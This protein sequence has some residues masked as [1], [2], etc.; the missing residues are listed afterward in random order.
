MHTSP[1]NLGRSEVAAVIPRQDDSEGHACAV[2][3]WPSER[4][5]RGFFLSESERSL[6]AC[7]CLVSD[8]LEQLVVPGDVLVVQG[9]TA[10]GQVGVANGPLGQ[11]LLVAATPKSIWQHSTEAHKFR[12]AW[13]PGDVPELWKVRT[14]SVR[15]QRDLCIAE[16]LLYVETGTGRFKIAGEITEDLAI[17]VFDTEAVEIWQSP[18]ELRQ[19]LRGDLVNDV[20]EDMT[21]ESKKSV[22]STTSRQPHEH[23]NS[24]LSCA[25]WNCLDVGG[26]TGIVEVRLCLHICSDRLLAEIP[27]QTCLRREELRPRRATE[28][29][30]GAGVS[31]DASSS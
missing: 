20:L 15:R 19:G 30:G 28:E 8:S 14:L 27:V 23:Q 25:S 31:M 6:T 26:C 2:P 10:V 12:N 9:H 18:T 13:P 3:L 22:Q 24:A 1:F 21:M 11:L 17:V 29:G 7:L 5:G 16:T 4:P